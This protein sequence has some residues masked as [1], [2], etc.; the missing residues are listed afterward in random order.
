MAEVPPVVR[1]EYTNQ[2]STTTGTGTALIYNT[3]VEDTHSAYN[4]ATG[5]FTAPMAGVY[6]FSAISIATSD[7]RY[8]NIPVSGIQSL[9][10]YESLPGTSV[11]IKSE[12]TCRLAAGQTVYPSQS[13]IKI[14][15]AICRFTAERIGS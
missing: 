5:I 8:W 15:D 9:V 1:A 12:M 14:A 7:N 6:R 13:S 2:I 11:R 10:Q 4:P 3:K